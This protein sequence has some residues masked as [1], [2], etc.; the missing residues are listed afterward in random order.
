LL[1]VVV[2][3]VIDFCNVIM[4]E[5]V[6]QDHPRSLCVDIHPSIHVC[7]RDRKRINS[8]WEIVRF[9]DNIGRH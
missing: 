3:S 5:R 9:D 7:V 4:A 6:Q 1:L 2:K 8:S